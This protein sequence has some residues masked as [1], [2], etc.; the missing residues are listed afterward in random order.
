VKLLLDENLSPRLVSRIAAL[1]A[2]AMHVAHLGQSGASDAELWRYAFQNDAVIVTINAGDFL[3]L[4][5][6][7]E[8]HPGLIV[9]RRSGLS[10]EDQW[11]FLEPA[12]RFGL[13][14]EE[15][16]RS[17][18]NRIIEITGAGMLEIYDMPIE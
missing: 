9:L 4:A 13:S 8:L 17:L 15:A 11:R 10:P 1:G 6:G 7:A 18:V 3:V 5:R 14:E 2:F 12:I 16:D